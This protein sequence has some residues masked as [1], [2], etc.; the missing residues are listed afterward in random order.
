MKTAKI[1]VRVIAVILIASVA[2]GMFTAISYG[3]YNKDKERRAIIILP[4][5]FASGLYDTATG[6]GVWDP[7]ESLDLAFGDVIGP[8]GI[9]LGN[10]F[11]LL[12][13]EALQAELNKLYANEK[14]GAEDSLF[15]LMAVN[16]DGSPSVTTVKPVPWTSQSRL[17]FGVINAQKQMYTFLQ[18][19]YGEDYNV[20]VFNYDFRLDNRYC[21]AE[22]EKYINEMGYEEVILVSHSNGG[23]VA[24]AYLAKSEANRNKVKK[25]ISYN[26]PYYGSFS[27]IQILENV[28]AMLAGAIS[29]LESLLPGSSADII[30][31]FN[32]QFIRLINVW[33]AYQLLPSFELLTKPYGGEQAGYFLDGQY[34]DF[35]SKE[36]LYEFYCSRPWAKMSDGNL[37][38]AMKEWLE[39]KDA[40][41]VEVDGTRVLST[42]LVDT[43]YFTGN[44]VDS[45]YQAY[46]RTD[47]DKIVFDKS[48]SHTM[49]D[50][51]VSLSSSVAL[52]DDAS[53]IIVM[54]GH[55]HYGV[56]NNYLDAASAET[57]KCIDSYFASKN[58]RWYNRFWD[59]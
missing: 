24:A 20:Q 43:T 3:L 31:V 39:Y 51:T 41:T 17:K 6:K 15:N 23:Q 30:E 45:L 21:A 8:D 49:G 47:G 55:N 40:L 57:K 2:A 36:E 56:V 42:T 10:V 59:R 14:Y 37:R 18:N 32:K 48:V 22:L 58:R 7:L 35:Q 53:C 52:L 19:N 50:G 33:T 44:G 12:F 5:L 4:G 28:N 27:A 38:P 54:D 25:Y 34:M 26:S 11:A 29:M 13:E 1:I 16:E 46:F 9:N